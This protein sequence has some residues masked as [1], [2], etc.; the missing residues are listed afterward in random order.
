MITTNQA[1]LHRGKAERSEVAIA[2]PRIVTTSWD[3]GDSYDLR[4]AEILQARKLAGTFYVPIAG[5]QG[6]SAMDD[7][8]LRALGSGGFEIG[9]HGLSHRVLSHCAK[10]KLAQEV[11][12][13]KKRLEEILGTEVR[14]FAYPRGRYSG[15]AIRSVK[16]AGYAG[17]RT[18]QML[19]QALNF[20][21]YKMPT[22]VHVFPH[23]KSDYVRNAARAADFGAGWRYLTQL[24]QVDSWVELAKIMF[25]S[26]LREG[27]IFHLYGH[28]WEI[29]EMGL[30]NDLKEVL[31]YVSMREG[32]LYLSNA[33]ILDYAPANDRLQLEHHCP[34]EG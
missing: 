16:Q 30:W 3:D 12:T 13:C 25:D 8:D 7:R 27:G 21:P 9:A 26:V 10:E 15:T 18:T 33:G 5:H 4:V 14:M 22:T 31:D 11:E 20:D 2:F 23:S 1:A 32:V 28:S 29:D 24:R 34:S 6:S 17:A 19:V